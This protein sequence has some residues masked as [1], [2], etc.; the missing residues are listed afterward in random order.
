[1]QFLQHAQV[2]S[3][4]EMTVE[5]VYKYHDDIS[6]GIKFVRIATCIYLLMN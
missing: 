5:I 2:V 4:C 1:M 3:Y 6:S